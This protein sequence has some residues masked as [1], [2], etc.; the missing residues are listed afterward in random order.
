[1]H[2]SS[3]PATVAL[4]CLALSLGAT[5]TPAFAGAPATVT[6]R[7]EGATETKLPVTQV[8][9]TTEPVVKDG[10]PADS[11]PGT[12][13]IGALQLATAGN[14]SGKWFGGGLVGGKFKGLGYEVA[15]VLGEGHAFGSGAFWDFWYDNREATEGP[16]EHELQ[17]GDQ[18]LL[19]PCPESAKECLP[20]GVEAPGS[21]GVG[22]A[23]QITV[24]KYTSAGEGSPV[25]GAIITGA[26][27]PGLTDASGHATVKFSS[28]GQFTL[29]AS[30][31]ELIRA[32][33]GICIHS[34]NDGRCGTLS[35]APSGGSSRQTSSSSAAAPPYNGPYAVVARATGPTDGRV[36]SRSRA[37]RLLTGAVTAHTAIA[38]VSIS[39]RRRHGNRCSA[40]SGVRALFVRAR[41]GQAPFFR[42]STASTFSYLLPS[43]LAP[44]RYVLDIEAT[45][46]AGNRTSLARGTSRIVFYVR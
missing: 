27:A 14:W 15:T 9:T 22:E 43:A 33:A 7:V 10:N 36:Y 13:A 30:A 20:L 11:C 4:T 39:L 45:D 42:V 6:V 16:C 17:P 31:P 32:E 3:R 23:I 44:G 5:A 2:A 12:N 25:S 8:T 21:A 40:Y 41:C 19:F 26:A 28:A 1:M 18:I 34:G 38:S 37:P 35:T 24:K 29:R 46:V